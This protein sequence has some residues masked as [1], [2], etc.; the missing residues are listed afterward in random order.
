M[1]KPKEYSGNLTLRMPRSM[2][3]RLALLAHRDD[4]SINT[5]IVTAVAQ[6]VGARQAAE[7]VRMACSNDARKPIITVITK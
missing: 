1:T 4:M 3:Q 7:M 2:H 5:L 6:E